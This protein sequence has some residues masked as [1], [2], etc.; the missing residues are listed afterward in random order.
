MFLVLIEIVMRFLVPVEGVQPSVKV[1]GLDSERMQSSYP[2][3]L[4]QDVQ[5]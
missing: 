4:R 2:V 5:T 3:T 1:A